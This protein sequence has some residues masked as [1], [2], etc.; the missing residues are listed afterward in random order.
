MGHRRG[1]ERAPGLRQ[2]LDGPRIFIKVGIGAFV[3]KVLIKPLV[4]IKVMIKPLASA[5]D[6]IEPLVTTGIVIIIFKTLPIFVVI[7]RTIECL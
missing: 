7:V 5:K 6:G 1:R 4:F 3:S 2:G